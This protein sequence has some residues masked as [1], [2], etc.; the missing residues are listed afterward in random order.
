MTSMLLVALTCLSTIN[1]S[2]HSLSMTSLI[3]LYKNEP[4]VQNL[5]TMNLS[6]AEIFGSV[7][8]LIID[9]LDMA[10][11][12]LNHV[13]SA[14]VQKYISLHSIRDYITIAKDTSFIFIYYA[15]VLYLMIEMSFG[16]NDRQQHSVHHINNLVTGTWIFGWIT[17][18]FSIALWKIFQCDLVSMLNK[19]VYPSVAIT[20][21]ICQRIFI[22]ATDW[23][24]KD[25]L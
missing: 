5:L 4:S 19:F 13:H 12:S 20:I 16:T 7:C 18:L 2:L 21:M 23:M 11:I 10:H 1:I 22:T 3:K 14:E 17:C 24:Q 9:V 25:I 8:W 15:L 6:V